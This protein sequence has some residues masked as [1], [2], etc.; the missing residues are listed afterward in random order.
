[1]YWGENFPY[2]SLVKVTRVTDEQSATCGLHC[3]NVS[4]Y[5]RGTDGEA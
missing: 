2:N 5:L 4:A 3:F 1:M